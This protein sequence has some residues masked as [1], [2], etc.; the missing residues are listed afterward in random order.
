MTSIRV[1]ITLAL[2]G[3]G[4][5]VGRAQTPDPE[6]TLAIDAPAGRTTVRCVRGCKLQGA[7]DRGNPN[8]ALMTNYWYT[9]SGGDVT[10]CGAQVNGWLIH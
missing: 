8:A 6:F 7:R 9:C 3:F 2:V 4:W 1:L 10:R 5:A